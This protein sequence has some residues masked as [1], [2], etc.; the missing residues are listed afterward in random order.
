MPYIPES[1][2]HTMQAQVELQRIL[3]EQFV[4]I[5]MRNPSY[6]LRAFARKIGLNSA[7]LSEILNS[8]RNISKKMAIRI[9]E[10]LELS[11]DVHNHLVNLFPEKQSRK[12]LAAV[13]KRSTINLTV[14]QFHIMSEWFHFAILSLA[15]TNSFQNDPKWIAERLNIKVQDAKA[16]I[17]RL[18]RLELLQNIDGKLVPTGKNVQS[19]DHSVNLSLRRS[20]MQN[21]ELA[22][23]SLEKDSIHI[24]DFTAITMA[25]DTK[26]ID[27][28]KKMIREFRDN[29]CAFMESG[30]KNEVFKM[31][32]Q[33]FPLSNVGD[34]N[35]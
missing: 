18:E 20:H 21:L 12:N 16:A 19:P 3:H 25:I 2:K 26:K 8:K 13:P 15:E 24:R 11:P 31:C 14:D 7:A 29:L 27:Q 4:E 34:Q 33:L 32:I 28:A 35:E 1:R 23:Q 30:E 10:R 9:L 6:S 17:E 22:K 5:Q